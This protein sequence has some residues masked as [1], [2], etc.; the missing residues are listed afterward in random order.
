MKFDKNG[1]IIPQKI[2]MK[3]THEEEVED[4]IED[5]VH[6]KCNFKIKYNETGDA[7]FV[8]KK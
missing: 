5:Y 4:L 7:Q 6:K 3:V 8:D 1:N 2:N